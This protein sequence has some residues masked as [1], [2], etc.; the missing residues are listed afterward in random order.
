MA[1][2]S[3]S[4]PPNPQHRRPAMSSSLVRL[5]LFV[6]VAAGVVPAFGQQ[7]TLRQFVRLDL[8]NV[9]LLDQEGVRHRFAQDLL[10]GKVAVVSFIFTG[11][12]TICSP[13][14]ANMG[15]LDKMLGAQVESAVSLLSVTL[16]PF[17][18][19]PTRLATWR[20]QFDDGPGWRL[21]T[22]DPDQVTRVL[23]AMRQDTA[24]IA[25]HD[26]FLWIGN[27][28]SMTW[29]RVSSLASPDALAALVRRMEEE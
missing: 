25:Q 11:C 24:D 13:V 28:R 17:N 2:I 22:G 3:L 27:L 19:T 16:D 4:T 7:S 20:R 21:L 15:A 26:A 12:T 14:G 5:C 1:R 18:D 23:H 6:L 29:M 8:P 9:S 10:R